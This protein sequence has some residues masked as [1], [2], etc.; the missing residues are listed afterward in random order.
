MVELLRSFMIELISAIRNS[1][2]KIRAGAE[3]AFVNMAKILSGF[4]AIPQLFQMLLVGLA[5]ETP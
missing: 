1:N 3:E 5:G 4:Q 2:Q